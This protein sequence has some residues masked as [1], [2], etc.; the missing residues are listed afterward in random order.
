MGKH[1]GMQDKIMA[2]LQQ[3]RAMEDQAKLA[4][5]KDFSGKAPSVQDLRKEFNSNK[6]VQDT[7]KVSSAVSRMSV[8]WDEYQK[9]PD[10]KSLNALDQALVI[11]FNKMLDPG[12]VVRESE[13]ARTPQGQALLARLEGYKDK[14][15]KGGVG[16]T[17]DS[18]RDIV[19]VA[20]QLLQ[21]QMKEYD[22]VK[23]QFTNEANI[24]GYD[25]NRIITT[26]GS[27]KQK[28]VSKPRVTE[29]DIDGMS[30]EELEAYLKE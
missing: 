11:T 10:R 5:A 24:Y 29:E 2:P 3:K 30:K 8:A 12:S 14:I 26:Y 20:N 13:F 27:P 25:P 6:I 16:L 7:G 18:R 22:K 9:N 28:T 17:D 19:E 23:S 4:K 21:G 15:G 1:F